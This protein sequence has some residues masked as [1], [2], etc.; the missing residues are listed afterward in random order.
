[1]G[2]GTENPAAGYKL[3]VAGAVKVDGNI[4]SKFQDLAEWQEQRCTGPEH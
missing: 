1:M 4:A 2:I 3:H